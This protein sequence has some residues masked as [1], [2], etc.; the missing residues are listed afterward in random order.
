MLP[1]KNN[2]SN[3]RNNGLS[4]RLGQHEFEDKTT[5][6]FVMW[7]DAVSISANEA[8]ARAQE[9]PGTGESGDALGV[10]MTWLEDE[11]SVRDRIEVSDLSDWAKNAGISERTLKRAKQRLGV[12][13]KRDG[14]GPGAK[15]YLSLP[16]KQPMLDHA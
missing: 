1:I 16:G 9:T 14:F 3:C 11:F 5:A 8:L 2:L 7:D 4:Y 10:A 12:V 13:S 15:Y 6:P